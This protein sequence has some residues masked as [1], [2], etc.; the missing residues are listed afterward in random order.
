[1]SIDNDFTKKTELKKPSNRLNFI[2]GVF[3]VIFAL[4]VLYLNYNKNPTN[5]NNSINQNKQLLEKN[6]DTI[7]PQLDSISSNTTTLLSQD[8]ILNF[9]NQYYQDISNH[10]FTA[11]NYFADNVLQYI[12]R[13]NLTPSDINLI[14]NNNNDFIDNKSIIINNQLSFDRKDGIINFYNYWIDYNCYRKSKD[15]Y[16]SCKVKVEIGLNDNNKIIS[17][18]ELEIK[19]LLFQKAHRD[20]RE[21]DVA[22]VFYDQNYTLYDFLTDQPIFPN[23][24]GLYDIWYSSN[25]D[26][27]PYNIVISK[28]E[29]QDFR[30]YKFKNEANCIQ[31]C[32]NKKSNY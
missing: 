10:N 6:N 2:L 14:V 5:P 11:E 30:F 17:Y 12:N 23:Q 20:P 32:N 31:W 27:N 26:P 3:G 29:L 1:M 22:N 13:A 7:S 8:E 15:K 21:K 4:V 28:T 25:E 19:D 16:Q 9:V 24:D 18:R